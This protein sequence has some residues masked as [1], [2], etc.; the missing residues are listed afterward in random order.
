MQTTE[1]SQL[2]SLNGQLQEI[3]SCLSHTCILL[4]KFATNANNSQRLLDTY[5]RVQSA[6]F[7]NKQLI[8]GG[9]DNQI[10]KLQGQ[11]DELK[12][13]LAAGGTR[14]TLPSSS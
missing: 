9:I 11:I 14:S 10:E 8:D 6:A 13:K 1:L 12:K 4:D 2:Q 5:N 3:K 7:N